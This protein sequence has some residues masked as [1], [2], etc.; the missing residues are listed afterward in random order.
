[1]TKPRRAKCPVCGY[2]WA[3][4]KKGR[5]YSHYLW[6]GDKQGKCDGSLQTVEV[7]KSAD[8]VDPVGEL[9]KRD[10]STRD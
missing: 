5:I 4:S 3:I 10:L 9:A 1:M 2:S 7:G 8:A 6:T